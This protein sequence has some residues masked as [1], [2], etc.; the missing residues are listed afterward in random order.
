MTTPLLEPRTLH[1][2]RNFFRYFNR[3]MML[4][5]HLGLGRWINAWPAVLGRYM[6]IVHTGRKSGKARYTPV[7]Y[8]EVDGEIYC[9][10]GFG[11]ISD[12]Y[13]NITAHPEVEIWLPEGWWRGIAE[14][15]TDSPD[16]FRLLTQVLIGSGFVAPLV[17]IDPTTITEQEMR[18]AAEDYRLVHIRRIAPCTG[19]GGPGKWAWVWPIATVLLALLAFRPH[20]NAGAKS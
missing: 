18:R 17:G 12:W 20:K 2:L 6:V 16:R 13:R 10:A 15:I 19:A 4:H 11:T 5:W 7:N 3:F 9:M 1:D 14:D 8:A